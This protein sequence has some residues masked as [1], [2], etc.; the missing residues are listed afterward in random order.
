MDRGCQ[1][2]MQ[3][4]A[5]LHSKR[6]RMVQQQQWNAQSVLSDVASGAAWDGSNSS[7]GSSERSSRS[8]SDER[9]GERLAG[10]AVCVL[11]LVR[12]AVADR[13]R[14]ACSR[15]S[16]VEEVSGM[17]AVRGRPVGLLGQGRRRMGRVGVRRCV[18]RRLSAAPGPGGSAK[19]WLAGRVAAR[20]IFRCSVG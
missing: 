2:V 9:R 1:F 8:S 16:E 14:A 3:A 11:R 20:G 7:V 18:R 6:R 13:R 15:R 12:V 5:A 19:T 4:P 17:A 10:S